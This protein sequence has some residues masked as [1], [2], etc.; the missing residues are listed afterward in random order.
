M[1]GGGNTRQ[2]TVTQSSNQEP[3]AAAQPLLTQ[4]LGQAAALQDPGGFDKSLV[5][6]FSQQTLQG[7]QGM[8]GTAN[9]NMQNFQNVLGDVSSEAQGNISDAGARAMQQVKDAV[10]LG[11][12]A[13]GRGFSSLHSQALGQGMQDVLYDQINTARGQLPGA[14]DMALAPNQ[15]LTDIGGTYEQQEANRLQDEYRRFYDDF[16]R[17]RD[18]IGWKSAIGQGAGQLGGTAGSNRTVTTPGPNWGQTAL[19]YGT[20]ALGAGK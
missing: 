8:E 6:P 5:V 10:N 19:G 9:Q 12:D 2:S 18:L 15:L 4:T 13:S 3:W 16:D 20:A 14:F 7:L 11:M 1:S 17:Q